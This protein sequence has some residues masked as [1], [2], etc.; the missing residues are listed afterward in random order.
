MGAK[1]QK[2]RV[3]IQRHRATDHPNVIF[4]DDDDFD[5]PPEIFR[6]QSCDFMADRVIEVKN[7]PDDFP[8]GFR[9]FHDPRMIL[10]L[11]K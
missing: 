5:T 6:L 8:M 7:W 10:H 9:L 2:I 3:I 4:L 1:A 11:E